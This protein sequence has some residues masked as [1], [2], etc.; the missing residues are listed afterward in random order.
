MRGYWP[1]QFK[2]RSRPAK[3]KRLAL[4]FSFRQQASLMLL[5]GGSPVCNS[6]VAESTTSLVGRGFS[7]LCLS[8]KLPNPIKIDLR[9]IVHHQISASL[10]QHGFPAVGSDTNTFHTRAFGGKNASNSILKYHDAIR[11]RL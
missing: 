3:L 10:L 4:G 8:E 11:I 2:R 7:L 6:A 1:T 9:E 5:P